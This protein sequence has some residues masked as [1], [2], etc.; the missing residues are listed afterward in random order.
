[1]T[2]H[3][4][5][6]D[7][8]QFYSACRCYR[9]REEATP[10]TAELTNKTTWAEWFEKHWHETLD[11]YFVRVK[12]D[13]LVARI[14]AFEEQAFGHSIAKQRAEETRELMRAERAKRMKS[15]K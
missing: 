13:N 12:A 8:L 2:E 14:V 10:D 9:Q 6:K 5:D 11:A 15:K 1:M 3:V 7:R 4:T